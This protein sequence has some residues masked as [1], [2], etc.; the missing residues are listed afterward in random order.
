MNEWPS[1]IPEYLVTRLLEYKI[2]TP[3]DALL[4]TAPDLSEAA[5]ISLSSSRGILTSISKLYA[6]PEGVGLQAFLPSCYIPTS[7]P[8]LDQALGGGLRIGTLVEFSGESGVGKTQ[9][10]QT[11][12]ASALLHKRPVYWIDTEGTFR[13]ERVSDILADSSVSLD[14][15][16]VCR[17]GSIVEVLNALHRLSV[18]LESS[19]DFALVV[20]DSIASAARFTTEKLAD[21]Q[22]T[23]HQLCRLV[24]GMKSVTVTTNHVIGDLSASA[25]RAFKPALGNTWAHDV[26]A[27]FLMQMEDSAPSVKRRWIEV[28]KVP[29]AVDDKNA[30]VC[31]K[32]TSAGIKEI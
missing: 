9:L 13:P 28:V 12:A 18:V 14:Y 25:S 11:L 20:I 21:R 32:I 24:K 23:L 7:L 31:I 27:R 30:T 5:G 3:V 26:N 15:L 1:S 10:C 29:S 6:P 19:G 4:F 16:S 2:L 8:K 22:K 17:C